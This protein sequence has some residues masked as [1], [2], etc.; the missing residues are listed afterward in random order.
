MRRRGYCLTGVRN[1]DGV[2]ILSYGR[3]NPKEKTVTDSRTLEVSD[4]N[5]VCGETLLGLFM[6]L[7]S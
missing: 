1:V 2:W 7:D 6:L 5:F 3:W 4:A